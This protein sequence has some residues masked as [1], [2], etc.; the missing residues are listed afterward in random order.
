MIPESWRWWKKRSRQRDLE[1]SFRLGHSYGVWRQ[2]EGNISVV[3]ICGHKVSYTIV[4]PRLRDKGEVKHTSM[5]DKC[6][7]EKAIKLRGYEG[8]TKWMMRERMMGR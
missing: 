5:C 7:L 4:E 3:H 2:E 1:L 6:L 8:E